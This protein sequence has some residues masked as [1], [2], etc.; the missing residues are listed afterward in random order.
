MT[1][2]QTI[3]AIAEAIQERKQVVREQEIFMD[4]IASHP[5]PDM[6]KA[7]RRR[8]FLSRKEDKLADRIRELTITLA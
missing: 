7:E 3:T 6:K 4:V 1:R 8:R 5:N 2:E